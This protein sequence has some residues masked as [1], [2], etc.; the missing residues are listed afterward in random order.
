MGVAI[1]TGDIYYVY[2]YS[3]SCLI[4]KEGK[5]PQMNFIP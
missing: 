1:D 4:S 3:S 5:E 2:P